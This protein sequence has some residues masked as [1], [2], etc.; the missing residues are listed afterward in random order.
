MKKR[1]LFA[2]AILLP[3]QSTFASEFGPLTVVVTASRTAETIEDTLAAVTV[4]TRQEIQRQQAKSVEDVLK[5]LAGINISNNGG[6]GKATSIFLRGTESDHLL[7]LIDGVKVGSAT[8]GTTAFQHIPVEQIERIEIV[9]GPLSSL[10]GSEAIGGVLQIFTRKGG[11]EARPFLSVGVGSFNT[12]NASLGVSGGGDRGW[13]SVSASGINTKGFNACSGKPFPGGAGCFTVEP[14]DDGYNNYSGSL[15]AGYQFDNGLELD[16]HA[17]QAVGDTEFDGSFQNE[18]ESKQ[19]VLGGSVKFKPVENWQ[20]S[21][22]AGRSKDESDNFKDGVFSTRF[23]T[24]RDTVSLLNAFSIRDA[25]LLTLGLDYQKDKVDSIMNDFSGNPTNF[26]VR[27]RDNKGLF[28]QYMGGFARQNLQL[29]LRRD[30]NEQFGN[31]NTGNAVW[32]VAVSNGLRFKASYGTAF[33]APTF[34]ELY[35]PGFGNAALRPEESKSVEFALSGNANWGSWSTHVFETNIDNLIAFDASTFAPANIGQ[36][37]IRGFEAVLNG[38]TRLF[39]LTTNITLL[40]PEN[41]SSGANSGNVLP[42][43]AKQTLRFD[44]SH[45]MGRHTFGATLVAQGERYDDLANT[46]KLSGYATVDL[47]VEHTLT[48][49]WLVLARIENVLD[50]E[51]ETAAFFNQPGRAYYITLRYQP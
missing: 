12:Y 44:V 43:R 30:D 14:D 31:H 2:A 10:Y 48:Q 46:R 40:D 27:S 19:Q 37:R 50:K 23:E 3:A 47:R 13:Y 39:N 33:K 21:L 16:A 42:R 4:I 24:T 51:Y 9:R 1:Y 7:V 18:S 34:N 17:L 25:D 28:V 38:H 45:Q 22:A 8:L 11:G 15:R 29:S 35:F 20:L 5:G 36:A 32:A 26:A 41:R 49:N 6:A